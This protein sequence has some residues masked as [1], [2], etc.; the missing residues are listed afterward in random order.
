MPPSADQ[1][2]LER[3]GGLIEERSESKLI[4][5]LDPILNPLPREDH[6]WIRPLDIKKYL[7]DMPNLSHHRIPRSAPS[8]ADLSSF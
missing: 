4:E 3:L 6:I 5:E 7:N 8:S 1:E 2:D